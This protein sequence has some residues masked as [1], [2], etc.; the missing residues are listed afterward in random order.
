MLRRDGETDHRKV[1]GLQSTK[2][3]KKIHF[4]VSPNLFG[5]V[6]KGSC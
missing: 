5:M 6:S 1:K 2:C 4:A 3:V